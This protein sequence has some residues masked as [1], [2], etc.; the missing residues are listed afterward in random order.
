METVAKIRHR[1]HVKGQS[2]SKISR[3]LNVARNTVKKVL[4]TDTPGKRY[5]RKQA[6]CAQ[7]SNYVEDLTSLLE[8]DASLPI[9]RRHTA[10]RLYETLKGKGYEGAYDSVQR[11]VKKWREQGGTLRVSAYI[12]LCFSPGEAYQFDWSHEIVEIGGVTQTIRVAHIRLCF[13]RVFRVVAYPRESQEMLFDAHNCAFEFFGGNPTRGIYDNLKTGIDAIFIGKE[14]RFN[15]RFLMMLSHYLIDPT[16]CTPGAGWEKG[17]VEN[18]VGNIREW[19]FVPKPVFKS[20]D[21]LNGWLRDRCLELNRTR[22]HPE[23]TERTL[24]E[25][26]EA[27]EKKSLQPFCRPFDGFTERESPVSSTCLVRFDHNRYSVD[28]RYAKRTVSVRSYARQIIMVAD[29]VI[30]GEHSRDFGKNKVIYNPWHYVPLL[31]RKPGALRNG[32]PF[33]EWDLSEAL[34]KIR[35]HLMRRP[36]GDREFVRILQAIQTE[37]L[38]AVSVTCELALA[39]NA[40]SADYVLNVLS[41]LRPS[42]GV[43][44]I[45]TPE[46]LRLVHEPLANCQRY[47]RL[48][49]A[50][51]QVQGVSHATP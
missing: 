33:Q 21:E 15:K 29:G 44:S 16:A 13:S 23:Q 19:L 40:V 2:I 28:C 42:P 35:I 1:H 32:A 27:E 7:L 46:Q 22:K 24:M 11:Y 25:V 3:E 18:Q 8:A 4:R 37:G 47:D 9:K 36:G 26:F 10:Q 51:D 6:V 49:C 30:V 38:E 20:F 48:L 50:N 45:A 17:Q 14:R 12:P 34:K 39:E 5:S 31:E 41:R 43:S